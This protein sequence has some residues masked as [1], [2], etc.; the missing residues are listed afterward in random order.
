MTVEVIQ[1]ATKTRNIMAQNIAMQ[2]LLKQVQT[3]KGFQKPQN[4]Q[5]SLYHQQRKN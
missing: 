5:P 1:M 3:E 2:E 4:V